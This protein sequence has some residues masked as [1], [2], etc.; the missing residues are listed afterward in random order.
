[1]EGREEEREQEIEEK[2]DRSNPEPVATILTIL[3][4]FLLIVKMYGFFYG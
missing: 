2:N 4:Y 1:M 3:V